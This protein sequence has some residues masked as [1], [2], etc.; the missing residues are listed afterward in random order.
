MLPR[1]EAKPGGELAPI[2]ELR[3]LANGRNERCGGQGANP[4]QLREALTRLISREHPL[5]L[6]VGGCDPLIHSP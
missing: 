5:D 3:R 6:L 2:F 1:D 4:G